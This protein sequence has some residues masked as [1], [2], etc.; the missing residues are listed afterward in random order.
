VAR[1][2]RQVGYEHVDEDALREAFLEIEKTV[3]VKIRELKPDDSLDFYTIWKLQ[4]AIIMMEIQKNPYLRNK[5][6]KFTML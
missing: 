3:S 5:I 4:T 1:L 6:E 2:L